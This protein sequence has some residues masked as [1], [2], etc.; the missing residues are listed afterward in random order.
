MHHTDSVGGSQ[1]RHRP[2]HHD[3]RCRAVVQF[4]ATHRIRRI[5]HVE[6]CECRSSIGHA[7][8]VSGHR[9]TGGESAGVEA[10]DPAG[11]GGIRDIEYVNASRTGGKVGLRSVGG[12]SVG[13]LPCACRDGGKGCHASW[14]SDVEDP[15]AVP[16][17]G[18]PQLIAA[19]MQGVGR[20]APREFPTTHS[21]QVDIIPDLSKQRNHDP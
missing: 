14:I 21:P 19:P 13:G 11:A 5:A 4:A 3:V 7:E 17:H 10:S 12:R 1:V 9:H 18:G 8:H 16:L 15:P 2:Q 20:S 6:Q